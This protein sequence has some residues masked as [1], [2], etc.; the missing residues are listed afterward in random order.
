MDSQAS[1]DAPFD[2]QPETAA[3][4]AILTATGYAMTKLRTDSIGNRTQVNVQTTIAADV[5]GVTK[6]YPCFAAITAKVASASP[7]A[8]R[9]RPQ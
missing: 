4:C 2:N 7:A 1:I 8:A 3:H 6:V 5:K 9:S